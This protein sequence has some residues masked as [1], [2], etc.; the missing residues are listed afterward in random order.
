MEGQLARETIFL[1]PKL[2]L[3]DQTIG[4][5]TQAN[6]PLMFKSEFDGILGL[7]YPNDIAQAQ[8]IVPVF[9]N[10]MMKG[11]LKK[12]MFSIHAHDNGGSLIWGSWDDNLKERQEDPFVWVPLAEK[13]YWTFFIVDMYLIKNNNGK[14]EVLKKD[15]KMCPKGCKGVIDTGS[16]FMYGPGTLINVD[17]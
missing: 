5:A 17:I 7:A 6:F 1:T 11:I 16:Y 8:N 12:P 4:F 10:L 9:D 3:P 13:N 15:E 14:K 2:S